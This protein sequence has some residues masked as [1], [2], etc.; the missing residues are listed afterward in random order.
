MPSILIKYQ[1]GKTMKLTSKLHI[2]EVESLTEQLNELLDSSQ[3]VYIEVTD[4]ESVDTASIQALC[5]LQK[6]LA[7]TGSSI[8]WVGSSQVFKKSADILGVSDFLCITQ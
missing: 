6:S 4:V 5:S 8:N 3:P 2:S 1:L 7:V